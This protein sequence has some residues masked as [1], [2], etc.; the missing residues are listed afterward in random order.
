MNDKKNYIVSQLKRTH[1]KKYENYVIT[2]IWHLINDL[3]IKIITQQYIVRPNG[4][5]LADLYFPQFNLI[6]EVDEGHHLGNKLNDSIRDRDVV[7]AVNFK[8]Y[9]IDTNYSIDYIHSQVGKLIDYINEEKKKGFIKRDYEKEFDNKQ[10]IE[11][12]YIDVNDN[13]VF[14]TQKDVYNCFGFNYNSNVQRSCINHKYIDNVSIWNPKL[15]EH[16]EWHNEITIDENIIYE[17]NK[18]YYKNKK[19]IDD[20]INSKR[21][22]RY[23]FAQSRD[24]LGR[25]LYRFKGEYRLNKKKTLE[26]QKA[27]WE[28]INKIVYTVKKDNT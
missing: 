2:R 8:I 23:V 16:G 27:V 18:D 10:Y 28:R 13:A 9:R 1:N 26:F 11:K 21:N 17:N 12:G 15:Y 22:V 25:I 14:R 4:Y 7:N 5:A 3:S 24:N 20:W 19:A 6:V